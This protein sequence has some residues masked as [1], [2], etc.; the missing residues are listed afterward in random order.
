MLTLTL[1]KNP[2]YDGGNLGE[3][4]LRNSQGRVFASTVDLDALGV[5]E[6]SRE[7]ARRGY[8]VQVTSPAYDYWSSL[9][10]AAG[11]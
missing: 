11:Y 5:D 6:L 7:E 4:I 2:V 10:E 3:W 8:K 9:L 1:E